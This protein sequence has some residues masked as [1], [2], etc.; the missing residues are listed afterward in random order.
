MF[1]L[2]AVFFLAANPGQPV[3]GLTYGND[4]FPSEDACKAFLES[5]EGTAETLPVKIMA[6]GRSLE[7]R[8]A[9]VSKEPG[10]SI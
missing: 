4:G 7:V 6:E 9:C 10:V 5:D 2:I 8:F 3:G 1:K